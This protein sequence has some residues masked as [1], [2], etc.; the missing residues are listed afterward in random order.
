M[1]TNRSHHSNST[2]QRPEPKLSHPWSMRPSR[3][4]KFYDSPIWEHDL[5]TG[6]TPKPRRIGQR[7]R[8]HA[9]SEG[10][11]SLFNSIQ[12]IFNPQESISAVTVDRKMTMYSVSQKNPPEV[13][14]FFHFFHKRLRIFNRFIF[15]HLLNVSMYA[16]LQIFIQLSPTLMKL[17]HSHINRD[18]LVHIICAKCPPLAETHACRCL[19]KSLIALLIVVC[20]KSL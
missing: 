11:S 8:R 5:F 12:F 15:T 16:M 4:A 9:S 10:R 18:Y 7:S 6:S 2:G 20:G 13:I 1:N 14:W 3:L 19:R 17:C